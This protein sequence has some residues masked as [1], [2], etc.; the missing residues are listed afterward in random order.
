MTTRKGQVGREEKDCASTALPKGTNEGLKTIAKPEPVAESSRTNREANKRERRRFINNIH[1]ELCPGI[2]SMQASRA[3]Q[4]RAG[5]LTTY[6]A[7]DPEC[8]HTHSLTHS[9]TDMQLDMGRGTPPFTLIYPLV[10][11]GPGKELFW[12]AEDGDLGFVGA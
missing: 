6:T 11:P 10:G 4:S 3:E 5:W 1:S 2:A 8:L 12:T 9:P 7:N